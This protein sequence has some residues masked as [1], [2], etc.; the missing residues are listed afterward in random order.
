[1]FTTK[2]GHPSSQIAFSPSLRDA[3]QGRGYPRAIVN[4]IWN[5]DPHGRCDR[6]VSSP[7]PDSRRRFA[8]LIATS[9]NRARSFLG[10]P[11]PKRNI[12]YLPN[13]SPR[14]WCR[15]ALDQCSLRPRSVFHP[16]F[17]RGSPLSV[18]LPQRREFCIAPLLI[19]SQPIFGT[20]H[21]LQLL[22]N[23]VVKSVLANVPIDWFAE[24]PFLQKTVQM[25]HFRLEIKHISLYSSTSTSIP[26]VNS[27][28]REQIVAHTSIVV[29][30][31]T[32][33]HKIP[34]RRPQSPCVSK[35]RPSFCSLGTLV[36]KFTLPL[37][38]SSN[39]HT[40]DLSAAIVSQFP[41]LDSPMPRTPSPT[42]RIWQNTCPVDQ[43]VPRDKRGINDCSPSPIHAPSFESSPL[44]P[45]L[46]RPLSAGFRR[47]KLA[48]AI[49]LVNRGK[50]HKPLPESG[51]PLPR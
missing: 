47:R 49:S 11:L 39:A 33:R 46:A 2:P 16:R 30:R 7:P 36:P 37:H 22:V 13:W 43:F 6:C 1:M 40:R 8:H 44:P 41:W 17:I 35:A 45:S 31:F 29:S 50:I 42:P 34:S 4:A 25:S 24:Y 3:Q 26:C 32:S 21:P 48:D 28:S 14:D 27:A 19:R 38:K 18:S 20:S 51:E 23:L 9:W 5:L 10:A 15:L 12:P